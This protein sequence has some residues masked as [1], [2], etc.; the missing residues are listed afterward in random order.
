M[1]Y[2]VQN[3]ATKNVKIGYC[4]DNLKSRISS[5]QTGSA[6]Q[7]ECI[8]VLDGTFR[9]EK[10]LHIRFDRLRIRGEWFEFSEDLQ[11][12][13]D[14]NKSNCRL[15]KSDIPKAEKRKRKIQPIKIRPFGPEDYKGELNMNA[16]ERDYLIKLHD[17]YKGNFLYM[18]I[19]MGK[20]VATLEQKL[21]RHGLNYVDTM[22]ADYFEYPKKDTS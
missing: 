1:I 11:R 6:E 18:A 16:M 2:F 20:T 10:T 8:M 4:K 3:K 19:H 12:F 22:P 13:L 14:D 5:L 21:A 15:E 7:L 17:R 9:D